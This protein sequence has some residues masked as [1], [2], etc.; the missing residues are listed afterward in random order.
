MKP[1][2]L[3]FALLTMPLALSAHAGEFTLTPLA[4]YQIDDDKLD[5]LDS[6]GLD[7]ALIYGGS[8]GYRFTPHW[9][10]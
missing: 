3:A 9:S 1:T 10:A 2:L 5:K 7:N 8:F 6:P 4:G